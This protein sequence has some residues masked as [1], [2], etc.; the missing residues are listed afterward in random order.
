MELFM[1][2]LYCPPGVRPVDCTQRFH[3]DFWTYTFLRTSL[4]KIHVIGKNL[5]VFRILLMNTALDM[6]LA[7]CKQ[8]WP[9]WITRGQRGKP[10]RLQP[11]V[12][13][14]SAAKL[15]LF[16]L[17][18]APV[19]SS[20]RCSK[21][22]G[23]YVTLFKAPLKPVHYYKPTWRRWW[24]C[25]VLTFIGCMWKLCKEHHWSSLPVC[26]PLHIVHLHPTRTHLPFPFSLS[27]LT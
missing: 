1:K 26:M 4:K 22:W 7:V 20:R 5:S 25:V 15:C 17:L 16:P 13:V 19:P 23:S 3:T 8:T 11:E 14:L 10:H 27:F 21:C 2:F 18:T 9:W 12:G 24:K 6:S